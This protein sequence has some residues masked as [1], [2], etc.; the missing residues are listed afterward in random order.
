LCLDPER[1]ILDNAELLIERLLEVKFIRLKTDIGQF[2]R[3]HAVHR[4]Q[5]IILGRAVR[6]AR[7]FCLLRVQ[8]NRVVMGKEF[9]RLDVICFRSGRIHGLVG[10]LADLVLFHRVNQGV[11]DLMLRRIIDSPRT[12]GGKMAFPHLMTCCQR[13][14]A[15]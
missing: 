1:F 14:L 2:Y 4:E 5:W 13:G 11:D 9:Q 10:Q 3:F 6:F 15:L 12:E 7:L 8:I